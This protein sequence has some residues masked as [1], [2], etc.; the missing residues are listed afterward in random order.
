MPKVIRLLS[1]PT[2]TAS[3]VTNPI[4][5]NITIININSSIVSL[6]SVF[7]SHYGAGK[8]CKRKENVMFSKSLVIRLLLDPFYELLDKSDYD[9]DR[10]HTDQCVQDSCTVN[11]LYLCVRKNVIVLTENV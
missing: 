10:C 7:L 8:K 2:A 6:L 9:Q 3:R 4:M 1:P 5:H 11:G